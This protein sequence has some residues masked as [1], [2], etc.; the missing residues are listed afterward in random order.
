MRCEVRIFEQT[1]QPEVLHHPLCDDFLLNHHRLCPFLFYLGAINH[2]LLLYFIN[3]RNILW[4]LVVLQAMRSGLLAIGFVV[5]CL[6]G[7]AQDKYAEKLQRLWEKDPEKCVEKAAKWIDR[8][9]AEGPGYYYIALHRVDKARIKQKASYFKRALRA[10]EDA[11]AHAFPKTDSLGMVLDTLIQQW[12]TTAT[13]HELERVLAAYIAVYGDTL[14]RYQQVLSQKALLLKQEQHRNALKGLDS[15]RGA[16]LAAA[17]RLEGIP[18]KWAGEDTNGFDCS[19]FTKYVYGQVGIELPHNAQLQA[20]LKAGKRQTFEEAQPGDLL[21]FGTGSGENVRVVHA[22]ILFK[23]ESDSTKVIH[24]VSGG[25]QVDGDNPA[26]EN[27]WKDR[28]LFTRSLLLA[29][30]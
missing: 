1:C 15:L 13:E 18:Y 4:K 24:C 3:Y 19:G 30:E 2:I 28:V 16:L 6:A 20:L 10:Y 25:V 27:H 17:L 11:L 29:E 26:W 23:K 22:A 5:M 7:K 12:S 21:F 14:A 9:K 8:E